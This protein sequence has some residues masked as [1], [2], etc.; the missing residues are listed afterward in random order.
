MGG[1]TIESEEMTS[2]IEQVIERAKQEG[3]HVTAT[4]MC[5]WTS[6]SVAV[7]REA[8]KEQT[9]MWPGEWLFQQRK[10]NKTHGE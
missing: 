1:K 2:L 4:Q 10:E 5:R 6:L 3:Y 9:G 8:F 7:F